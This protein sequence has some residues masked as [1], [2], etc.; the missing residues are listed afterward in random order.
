[1]V[2][3]EGDKAGIATSVEGLVIG[4]EI[5]TQDGVAASVVVGDIKWLI[6]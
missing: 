2:M 6:L 3:A 5:V 1:M 4:H